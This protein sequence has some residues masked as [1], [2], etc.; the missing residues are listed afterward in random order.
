MDYKYWKDVQKQHAQY[1]RYIALHPMQRVTPEFIEQIT[2]LVRLIVYHCAYFDTRK[3]VFAR[4]RT[5]SLRHYGEY[6]LWSNKQKELL[7]ALDHCCIY[8]CD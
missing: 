1:V 6:P 8:P 4:V 2:L 7:E 5:L 3:S